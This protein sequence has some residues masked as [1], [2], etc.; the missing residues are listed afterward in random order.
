MAK[1]PTLTR[2]FTTKLE[3]RGH[4]NRT[5]YGLC[6]PFNKPAT[7]TDPSGRSYTERFKAGAFARTLE[8][9]GA[10]R[11]KF[12][13]QHDRA[14]LPLGSAVLLEEHEA[15]LCGEFSVSQTRTG[16]ANGGWSWWRTEG[17]V[18]RRRT[19]CCCPDGGRCSA[20]WG[21]CGR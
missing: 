20:W 13:A 10:G 4:E 21:G 19:R 7:I 17:S 5:V 6:C 12:L 9:R 8:E 2:D 15:G 14:G 16:T 1:R 11:V 18:R 3:V